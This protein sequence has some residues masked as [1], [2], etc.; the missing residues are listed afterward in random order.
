MSKSALEKHGS[1]IGG[2]Y[3]GRDKLVNNYIRKM[4]KKLLKDVCKQ[5]TSQVQLTCFHAIHTATFDIQKSISYWLEWHDIGCNL[6]IVCMW[7]QS[8]NAN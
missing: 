3:V 7:K 1:W 4:Q 8:K 2:S 5:D 6:N